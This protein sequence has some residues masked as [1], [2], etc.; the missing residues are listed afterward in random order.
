MFFP[1]TSKG[2]K[3]YTGVLSFQFVMTLIIG[4]LT[5]SF[6][7]GFIVGLFIL[8]LPLALFNFAKEASYTKHVAVIASQLF[9][10]LHIQQAMGTTYMHFEIFAVMA[11]TIVYRDWRV[12]LSSVLIVAIHHVGFY[13]LQVSGGSVFIFE[14]Q[15]LILYVLAIHAFFAIAEGAV[16]GVLAMQSY[17]DGYAAFELTEAIRN[18]MKETGKFNI[19]VEMISDNGASQDFT[20]LIHGFSHVIEQ[21]QQVS[22]NLDKVAIEAETLSLEVKQASLDT[23]GQVSTMAAATEEMTVNNQSVSERALAVNKLSQDARDSSNHAKKIVE[24]SNSE[25][26]SLQAELIK[27]SSTISNLAEKCF[28]I[29]NVMAS[30]KAISEQTNLLALNAAIESAR[31]GEHG[32]GFAVVADEVRQLAMRTK[33]NTEQISEITA[34]LI[35]ESKLS[36]DNMQLCLDKSGKV[37]DSSDSAREI[38]ETVV[39][40]ISSVSENISSVSIAIKEQSLASTEIAR[41]TSLLELTSQALGRNADATGESIVS[42]KTE[43]MKLRNE[44][45]KFK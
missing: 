4:L 33:S 5:D 24:D 15:Y 16:L 13:S 30:I 11:V 40:N 38:I 10:A 22:E 35:N 18:M 36:V 20:N 21:A 26:V 8:L 19:N 44:L 28:Q 1:W 25:V 14:E 27:T 43:I 45:T 7:M 32:R 41:S 34:S 42:L 23:S 29:E 12:V 9:A 31:A 37:S 6:A 17:K 2:H 39:G 3:V